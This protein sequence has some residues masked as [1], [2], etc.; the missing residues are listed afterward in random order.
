MTPKTLTQVRQ[1]G[2]L[3]RIM[4]AHNPLSAI[5]PEEAGFDGV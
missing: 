4:A 3:A 1:Q 2:G 5:L